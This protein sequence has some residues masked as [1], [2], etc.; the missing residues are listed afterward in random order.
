MAYKLCFEDLFLQDGAPDPSIWNVE[1]GGH[2]FGNNED[3]YYTTR[4]KN[5]IVK[6]GMLSIIAH[7]EKYYHR[8]YTSAKLTTKGKKSIKY[9]R[10]E[11]VASLPKGKG[12]WP[13]IWFLGDNIDQAGW[14]LCGEIDLME[15]VG[16]H[17]SWIH[18]SLH[19]EGR[20]HHIGNQPTAFFEIDGIL[21]GFHAYR[22]D[23]DEQGMSFYVD[24][25]HYATFLKQENDDERYWPFDQGFYLI[26]NLAIGGTW[27][28]EIDDSIFPVSMKVKSV[29]VYERCE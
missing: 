3:Q 6:D 23:W 4:K 15:H 21:E 14:P 22:L 29:K 12:T 13:A 9:G 1:K 19:S 17:P 26:L 24:H 10:I 5:V 8:H 7:K 11:V 2:G 16:W 25:T 28:G 27:G 20:N 18:F